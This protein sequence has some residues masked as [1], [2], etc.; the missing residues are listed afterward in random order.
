MKVIIPG[1]IFGSTSIIRTFLG[2]EVLH[3]LWDAS[4]KYNNIPP[5]QISHSFDPKKK[6]KEEED[7]PL[8]FKIRWRRQERTEHM[9]VGGAFPLPLTP[10]PPLFVRLHQ[11]VHLPIPENPLIASLPPR[12][13][14][15]DSPA[16]FTDG[17][18][19]AQVRDFVR[20]D[21]LLQ[22]PRRLLRRGNRRSPLR[23]VFFPGRIRASLATVMSP[24]FVP[25]VRSSLIY[26]FLAAAWD[27]V[28]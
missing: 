6:K 8:Q 4:K 15:R 26:C 9:L 25:A 28:D 14:R 27:L 20:R 22:R 7:Q 24:T 17:G 16:S 10:P 23:F 18:S 11:P 12:H 2:R 19:Q 21:L 13:L 3:E 1:G 5:H